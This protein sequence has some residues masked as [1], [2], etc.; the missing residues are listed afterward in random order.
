MVTVSSNEAAKA[1]GT[2]TVSVPAGKKAVKSKQAKANIP[3]NGKKKLKLKFKSK[4]LKTIK[5]AI[6]KKGKNPK[7]KI[8]VTLTDNAGNKTK[9]KK[10]VKLKN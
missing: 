6:A 4:A 9:L 3:A 5:K 10:N 7:A 2:A 8:A 1:V